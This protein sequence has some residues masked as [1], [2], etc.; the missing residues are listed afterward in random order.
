MDL[1]VDIDRLRGDL[2]Q[3][4]RFGADERGGVTRTSFSVADRRARAWLA[5]RA[6]EAGLVMR[7]D[8]IGNVFLRAPGRPDGPAVWTGSHLDSV[9]N[10]GAFD[11]ALGSMAALEV[12]RRLVEERVAVRRPVEVVIFADEEGNYHHLCG[13]TALVREFRPEELAALRGRDGDRL[14]DALA[15]AGLDPQA[16]TRTAVAPGSVYAFV[17]LHIEQGAVLDS[18]GVQIGVV[19][20]IV[21]LGGGELTFTGRADHAGT[22]PMGMRRDALRA[23]ADLVLR[24]P[25]VTASVSGA[26]V[27]TCGIV[28][29]EPGAANVVPATCRLQLDFRDPDGDRLVGLERAIVAEAERAAARHGV[30]VAYRRDSITDPVRLDERIQAVIEAEAGRLGLSTM[31]MP[32]GAGHDSQNLAKLA[33]TG[34]IFVPSV[35]GRSHSPAEL[36]G[37]PDVENG[38]N[39]LLA[40]VHALATE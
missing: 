28:H 20:G 14:V 21:G 6:A 4:A 10:G 31:R 33:P 26:A 36:T 12:A 8:G 23:A 11:G 40:T 35:D 9:P 15:A 30:Q 29:V 18:R 19:T 25:E 32:S 17:E 16:A 38:A 5:E 37:W 27:A 13:S 39:L 24:L 7:T 22:T 1:R 34:M 3:L 2:E